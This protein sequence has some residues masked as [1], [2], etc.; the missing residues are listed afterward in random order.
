M[1]GLL[2]VGD[3]GDP[4][5]LRPLPANVHVERW[6]P[7]HEVMPHAAAMVGNGGFGTTLA[8]VTFGVPMVVVPLFVDQP[9]NARRVAAVGAGTAIE[10]GPSAVDALPEALARVLDDGSFRRAAERIADDIGAFPPVSEAASLLAS[11][12]APH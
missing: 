9:H 12:A 10:A 5:M 3:A 1:R 7:Q 6:W 4:E 2:A 8:A 11:L